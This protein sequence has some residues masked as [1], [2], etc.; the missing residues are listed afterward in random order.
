MFGEGGL[1]SRLLRASRSIALASPGSQRLAVRPAITGLNAVI[2]MATSVSSPKEIC[3]KNPVKEQSFVLAPFFP[4]FYGH[5]VQ[6]TELFFPSL[7]P[8]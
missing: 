5:N 6:S 8:N 4:D 2:Y 7:W 3:F 1:A